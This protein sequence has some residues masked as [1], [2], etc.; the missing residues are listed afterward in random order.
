MTKKAWAIFRAAAA[1]FVWLAGGYVLHRFEYLTAFNYIDN[2]VG[3]IPVALVVAGAAGAAAFW[4]A[5]PGRWYIPVSA[6]GVALMILS[7]ALFPAALRGN[8][9][10]NPAAH[11]PAADMPDLSVYAPF[12]EGA[13]TAKLAGESTL[14]L[15][16]E[17]P[18]LDGATALYP[19]YAAF[20][21]A[22]Y[23]QAYFS[24]D[25]VLCTNTRGAYEGIISGERDII[26]VAGASE[27][28]VLAARAAGADLR[29][30]PIGREAF[31]FLVGRENPV[32]NITYQQIRNIYS[33]KTAH[34]RTLGWPE[35]GRIIAFQRPED[36]GSQTGLQAIMGGMPIQVPQPLPD[37]GLIGSNSLMK[38]VSVEWGGVQPALGYSYRYYATTMYANPD[39]KLLRVHGAEPSVENIQNG[40]YPFVSDFYAVT[41]GEPKGSARLLID[42]I[43]SPQ[44]QELIEKTGY[45]PL[46]MGN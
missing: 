15:T 44:G 42:W 1:L 3:I 19:V 4:W 5:K 21:E 38:Q 24:E 36:S 25:M 23:D 9:W 31:V 37:A 41:N 43:L 46:A 40:N 12:S 33:G 7:A 17:L 16:E 30:T 29:F 45:T 27:K 26:F 14:R 13:K 35:G 6:G 32:D 20:A 11:D 28:Q 39:T 8:W 18:V 10:I 22:A 2:I 34:W